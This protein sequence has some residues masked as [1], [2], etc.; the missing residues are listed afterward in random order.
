MSPG[1]SDTQ[2]TT[3]AMTVGCGDGDNC[4]DDV[5]DDMMMMYDDDDG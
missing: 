1:G 2:A 4:S 5:D 3:L